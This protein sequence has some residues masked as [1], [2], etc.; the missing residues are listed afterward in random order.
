[1]YVRHTEMR[2][3]LEFGDPSTIVEV[4]GLLEETAALLLRC[5]C[6]E[7]NRHLFLISEEVTWAVLLATFSHATWRAESRRV[8]PL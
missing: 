1:M 4:S 5:S 8:K 6:C 3:A 7:Q 2:N